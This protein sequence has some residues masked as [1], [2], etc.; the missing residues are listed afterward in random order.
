MKNKI[1]I[2]RNPHNGDYHVEIKLLGSWKFYRCESSEH[3]LLKESDKEE[4]FTVPNLENKHVLFSLQREGE[5]ELML[6]ESPILL[7]GTF[8]FRDIGGFATKQEKRVKVGKLYRCDDLASL[9]QFDIDY[10][11][12]FHLSTVV[13]FRSQEE[14]NRANDKY[15]DNVRYSQ[16]S[17]SPGKISASTMQDVMKMTKEEADLYMCDVYRLLVSE[18]TNKVYKH[19][20]SIL[21]DDKERATLYHCSAGK[22]RTGM[23]TFFILYALGVDMDV[24]KSDYMSSN[25]LLKK[26]YEKQVEAYPQLE[27]MFIVKEEYIDIAISEI[28]R[29]YESIDK[30]LTDILEIDIDRFRNKYL[31]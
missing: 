21:Q 31:Y 22:D 20:F 17:I 24:I 11:E 9:T 27:A 1:K 23:A 30:Y 19:F 26:K 29:K 28:I 12:T 25:S 5:D 18:D 4:V 8:N 15:L 10:L 7:Q 14:I 6:S 3:I 2:L 16:L 13:D